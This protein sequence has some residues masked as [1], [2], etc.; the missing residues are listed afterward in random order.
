M[1]IAPRDRKR[2]LP[3]LCLLLLVGLWPRVAA[4]DDIRYDGSFEMADNGDCKAVIKLIP[5]M[6]VYQKLRESVS[7]L[8]LVLRIFASSRAD[9]E[10]VDKKAE[11]DDSNHSLTFSMKILGAAR[12]M[13]NHWEMTIP[14]EMEFSNLDEAKRTLY[15]NQT[16]SGDEW[17]MRGMGRLVLPANASDMKYDAG[18]RVAS[19]VLPIPAGPDSGRLPFVVAACLAGLGL[20]MVALSFVLNPSV[21]KY[22]GPA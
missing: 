16:E 22:S 8:Y 18:R 1:T 13:G 10:T 14:R 3:I 19:Y 6:V 12:N 7:N 21:K 2:L 15:F 5:P 20:V 9:T 17:S 4:A 11:W